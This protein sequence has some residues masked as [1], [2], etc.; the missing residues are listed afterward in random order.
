VTVT[1]AAAAPDGKRVVLRTYA[2]AFEWDVSGDIVQALT[3]GEPRVTPLPD[4]PWGEA[5]T[6]SADG[7]NFLTVSET[8]EQEDLEPAILRYAPAKEAPKPVAASAGGGGQEDT[9]SFIDKL[10]L[11]DITAIIGGVGVIG[12]LLVVAGV[13]G[14]VTARRRTAVDVGDGDSDYPVRAAAQVPGSATEVLARVR[15]DQRGY[16]GDPDSGTVYGAGAG[17]TVYGGAAPAGRS[18]AVYGAARPGGAVYGGEREGG[19]AVYGGGGYRS[20]RDPDDYGQQER[21][22]AYRSSGVYGGRDYASAGPPDGGY[23]GYQGEAYGGGYRGGDYDD[24]YAEQ[25]AGGSYHDGYGY[26]DGPHDGRQR[27]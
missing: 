26:D 12:V 14:I 2:D 18:G 20:N 3:T 25:P 8:A 5:I 23:G 13:L 7:A 19:G 10:D 17:G 1:G 24:G 27:R 9:R 4:E 22:G 15:P 21:G 16:D 6:Y 11:G